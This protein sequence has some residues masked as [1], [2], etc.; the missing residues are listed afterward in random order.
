MLR[1][2]LLGAIWLLASFASVAAITPALWQV[3]LTKGRSVYL[4]GTLHV[5]RSDF[6]PLPAPLSQALAS[7]DCLVMELALNDH[8]NLQATQQSMR[9]LGYL[10]TGQSLQQLLEPQLYQQALASGKAL[11]LLPA[12]S[13]RMQPWLLAVSLQLAELMQLGYQPTL[14]LD[15]HLSQQAVNRQ[16]RIVALETGSAQI[17]MLA[18]RPE[19]GIELLR[20][21]LAAQQR[22]D[23]QRLLKAWQQGD[24]QALTALGQEASATPLGKQLMTE[25]LDKRNRQWQQQLQQLW[26]QQS[27]NVAVG[28]L[29]LLGENSLIQLLQQAG[30]RIT[31][32]NYHQP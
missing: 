1:H 9:E 24:T 4:F 27:C 19:Y 6:Y 20:Q 26:Q 31:R 22:Q 18:S 7:S 8:A 16:Q 25:L 17:K 11:G 21:S 14:G 32:V 2:L 23:S 30:Y 29:H 15:S 10:P 5:G 28:A 3:E 12:V 13:E